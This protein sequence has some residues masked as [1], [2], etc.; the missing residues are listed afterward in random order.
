ME[1][2]EHFEGDIAVLTV[3]G[4][5]VTATDVAPFH[6][7]IKRLAD[8]GTVKVVLDCSGAMWFGSA[9]VGTIAAS[10]STLYKQE[11]CLVIAGLT[12]KMQKLFLVMPG[13]DSTGWIQAFD[14]TDQA[15]A[16]FQTRHP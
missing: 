16:W 6:P 1:I 9:M 10:L 2:E 15:V 13:R 7:H 12:E 5:M 3:A 11:G 8:Q 4:N 14:S